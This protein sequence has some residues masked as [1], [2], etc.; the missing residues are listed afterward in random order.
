MLA[1]MSLSHLRRLVATCGRRN[2]GFTAIAAQKTAKLDPIQQLFVDKIHEYDT[3]SKTAG[4]GL[5]DPSPEIGKEMHDEQEKIKRQYS[6]GKEVNL[7]DFPSFQF[8]EPS[9]DP[10]NMDGKK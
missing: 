9:V 8:T 10:I 4:G 2:I 6:D 5:V 7:S 1:R 3:K